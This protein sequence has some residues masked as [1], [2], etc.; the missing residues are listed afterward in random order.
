M[1]ALLSQDFSIDC[2][3][4]YSSTSNKIVKNWLQIYLEA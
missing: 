3:D 2:G 4:P 1:L